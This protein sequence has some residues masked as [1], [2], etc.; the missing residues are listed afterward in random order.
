MN[1]YI[2]ELCEAS[3]EAERILR[4]LRDYLAPS[5]SNILSQTIAKLDVARSMVESQYLNKP[6]KRKRI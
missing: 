3:I 2:A 4:K 6:K 1:L 5:N